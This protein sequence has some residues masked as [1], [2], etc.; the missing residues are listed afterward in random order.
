MA[1]IKPATVSHM[2]HYKVIKKC[3]LCYKMHQSQERMVY[4]KAVGKAVNELDSIQF[5]TGC[6]TVHPDYI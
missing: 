4:K 2:P 6:I 5:T 1:N 3:T